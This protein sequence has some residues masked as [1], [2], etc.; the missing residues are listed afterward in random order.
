MRLTPLT[1]KAL[2]ASARLHNDQTRKSDGSPYV[3]HPFS[4]AVLISEHTDDDEVIAAA[5][6]HD[7]LEDVAGYSEEDMR[8]DFGDRVTDIVLDVSEEKDPNIEEDKRAT[9]KDRKRKYLE[10]MEKHGMEALLVAAGDKL[11]NLTSFNDELEEQGVSLLARFNAGIDEQV[12][13]YG[14]MVRILKGRLPGELT[15]ALSAQ[16]VRLQKHVATFED[17]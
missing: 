3:I 5:L 8:R 16:Y 1:R 13:F 11:H 2:T 17:Q 9:W 7:I 4:V 10:G 14:E 12:W 6:L 15:E